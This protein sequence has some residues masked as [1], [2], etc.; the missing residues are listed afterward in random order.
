M[1]R[2]HLCTSGL[3]WSL[4]KAVLKRRRSKAESKPQI[5]SHSHVVTEPEPQ[6]GGD[7]YSEPD[8]RSSAGETKPPAIDLTPGILLPGTALPRRGWPT[9]CS[10]D[11]WLQFV[12]QKCQ[13]SHQPL[14]L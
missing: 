2:R 12:S 4:W 8:G 1:S 14:M 10:S 5:E 3:R 11:H 6:S 7:D 9:P 13:S